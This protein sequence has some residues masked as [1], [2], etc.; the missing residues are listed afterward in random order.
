MAGPLEGSEQVLSR[1]KVYP[2]P[3]QNELNISIE[4]NK[5]AEIFIYDIKGE[6][7]HH[8]IFNNGQQLISLDNF[9]TGIYMVFIITPEETFRTKFIK[10]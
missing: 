10:K 2:N 6:V 3:A 7:V 8:E 9:S 5:L 1:I 4:D